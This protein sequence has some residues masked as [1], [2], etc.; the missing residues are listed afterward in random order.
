[1]THEW[2]ELVGKSIRVRLETLG[3][4]S[5]GLETC[6]GEVVLMVVEFAVYLLDTTE[7]GMV[8]VEWLLQHTAIFFFDFLHF[9]HRINNLLLEHTFLKRIMRKYFLHK[10]IGHRL[11]KLALFILQF[12]NIQFLLFQFF[13]INFIQISQTLLMGYQCCQL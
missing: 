2:L 13:H 10:L 9:L 3:C 12:L 1:M 7:Y 8:V 4:F 5:E 11:I 6:A